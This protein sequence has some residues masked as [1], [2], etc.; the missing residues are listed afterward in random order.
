MK[1]KSSLIKIQKSN[2]YAFYNLF[3]EFLDKRA[4]KKILKGLFIGMVSTLICSHAFAHPQKIEQARQFLDK[5]QKLSHLYDKKLVDMY[6]NKAKIIR[7]LEKKGEKDEKVMLPVKAYK[8][9]L[10]Y[11]RF[12]AKIRGYKNYYKN[13]AYEMENENVRITGK[14]VNN[15][16][17]EAPVS[18]L[19]GENSEG[20]LKILE[21]RTATKS[22]FLIKQVFKRAN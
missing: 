3:F 14:R 9:M 11:V 19:V 21:E 1:F 10:G 8:K 5:F 22:E 12:F 13:L 4:L 16:G 2:P 17:Y 18:I 7:I 6:S 20:K 15:S